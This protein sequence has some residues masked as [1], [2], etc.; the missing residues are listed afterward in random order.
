MLYFKTPK[1]IVDTRLIRM[2]ISAMKKIKIILKLPLFMSWVKE[3][4]V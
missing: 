1:L 2:G 4:T 3:V